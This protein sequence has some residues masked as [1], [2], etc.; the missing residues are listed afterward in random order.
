MTP[1]TPR[2]RGR[3]MP[4]LPGRVPTRTIEHMELGVALPTS[5]PH[6]STANIVRIAKAAEELNYAALWTYERLLRPI[7]DLP[8]PGGPPRPLPEAYK[9]VFE[10]LETLSYVAAL[11]TRI[12]LGTS[13]VDALF[14]SPVV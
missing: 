8:Q 4:R 5:W 13:V 1:T 10:P 7:G 2:Y 9:S 11:T 6:G 12:K 14:H 3:K